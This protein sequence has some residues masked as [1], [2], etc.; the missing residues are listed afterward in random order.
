M[1]KLILSA[2]IFSVS[3][4]CTSDWQNSVN[5]NIKNGDFEQALQTMN[6][7][8]DDEIT[9][10]K[11]QID[12]L[13][14]IIN[15]I[16]NDFKLTPEEGVKQIEERIGKV[17]SSQIQEWKEKKYIE[18]MLIDGKEMW[19]RKA[20][21]NFWLLCPEY[22]KN[23]ESDSA[24]LSCIYNGQKLDST[25][26]FDWKK[27]TIKFTLDVD[28]NSVPEG[29]IITAWLPIPLNTVRQKN[30]E[31]ISAS[32]EYVK[33]E[34]SPH[35]TLCLKTKADKGKDTHFE[36][37]YSYD[38]AG[39]TYDKTD[40]LE[41]L[42][43]Y[44]TESEEY[45]NYTSSDGKHIL[46]TEDMKKISDSIVGTE[47][48][49]VLKCVKI[50]NWIC[51]NFPWAGARDYGTIKNIPEYVLNIK[52]GDCGQVTLLYITLVR[53]LGIPARW[54]SG[55]MLHPWGVNYHDWGET[56]FEGIG[57]V[58]TDVSFGRD[59]NQKINDFYKFSTDRYRMASNSNY[60]CPLSPTKKYLRTEPLDFQ[61]GE[62][63]WNGGN[64]E[65]QNFSSSLK[66]L[67]VENINY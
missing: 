35:N 26:C 34:N 51:S 40:L 14:I 33:S 5:E 32:H 57:W 30:F 36:I 29:E 67:N 41:N 15:R 47:T 2:L 66:I 6:N 62:V 45:K 56:Y 24:A 44:N 11:R 38:V 1:K 9:N 25:N 3:V 43:P 13:T 22:I 37:V 16:K 20:V 50:Y 23:E 64:I 65:I 19:F 60:S 46:L 17:S 58:P 12:S 53:S 18:T 61:A 54:E 31:V 39:Q 27:M 52:H 21:R 63:E 42:K 7:L 48:N 49:P 59:N 55:W 28:S 8:S 4:S 10:N